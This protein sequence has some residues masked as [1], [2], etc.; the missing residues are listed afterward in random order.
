VYRSSGSKRPPVRKCS[1]MIFPCSCRSFIDTE[2]RHRSTR[3][4]AAAIRESRR[5]G[6]RIAV[7]G[8]GRPERRATEGAI[9][10]L[11]PSGPSSTFRESAFRR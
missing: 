10:L 4:T 3:A 7:T 9:R 2:S 6:R 5:C 11:T 1:S 8:T